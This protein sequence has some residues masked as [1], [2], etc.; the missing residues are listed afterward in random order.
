MLDTKPILPIA[1]AIIHRLTE[2]TYREV[3]RQAITRFPNLRDAKWT[4]TDREQALLNAIERE[5]RRA[6]ILPDMRHLNQNVQQHLETDSL[7]EEDKSTIIDELEGSDRT[8][9]PTIGLMN[10]ESNAQ[11]D[12]LYARCRTRWLQI[13]PHFASY[14]EQE[15]RAL[16][17]RSLSA[18]ARRA[19]GFVNLDGSVARP[20][21]Q[22]VESLHSMIAGRMTGAASWNATSLREMFTALVAERSTDFDLARCFLSP[23]V[24]ISP[25]YEH[26]MGNAAAIQ[27]AAA[28]T[29]RSIIATIRATLP[30]VDHS[31]LRH[32]AHTIGVTLGP[33]YARAR[34]RV[35]PPAGV[36]PTTNDQTSVSG[37][38]PVPYRTLAFS[39]FAP[40]DERAEPQPIEPVTVDLS[41]LSWPELRELVQTAKAREPSTTVN[42]YRSAWLGSSGKALE[43][44]LTDKKL[45]RKTDVSPAHLCGSLWKDMLGKTII[46]GST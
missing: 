31:M 18:Y 42:R 37:A 28:R 5:L 45:L 38:A 10:A 16:Y 41:G 44:F 43:T 7:T 32:D 1:S 46:S 11:F 8:V 2:Q 17:R 35:E 23:A 40:S 36:Q 4:V 34:D 25:A 3:I 29:R 24:R 27:A 26:V 19:I 12:L 22:A 30:P 39:L 6:A 20:Y 13:A 9:P 33:E 14:F 15:L 21:S